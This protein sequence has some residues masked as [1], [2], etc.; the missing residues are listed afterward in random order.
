MPHDPEEEA[1]VLL[2]AR[3]AWDAGDHADA[4][5]I[6]EVYLRRHPERRATIE[7][8]APGGTRAPRADFV[9]CL[10]CSADVPYAG[11]VRF[12]EGSNLAPFLLGNVGEL[13]VTRQEMD[14]YACKAC[15]HIE[16]FLPRGP[17]R[18]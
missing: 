12:H 1:E 6:L 9:T 10:R 11:R 4:A 18:A 5:R 7:G 2:Q 13:L 14:V 16:L 15:G 17:D 8:Q 3:L